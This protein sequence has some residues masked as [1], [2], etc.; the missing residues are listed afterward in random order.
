MNIVEKTHAQ[1]L[2][3]MLNNLSNAQDKSANSFSYDILSA[4]AIVDQELQRIVLELFKKFD[5]DNL[6]D[7][8]LE[9]RVLQITG[10][11]RKEPTKAKG[12]VT[13]TGENGTIIPKN[14]IFLA[15]DTEFLSLNEAKIGEEG[16]VEVLVECLESGATGD[17]IPNSIT[18][19]KKSIAGIVDITNKKEFTNGYEKETDDDLRERYYDKLL[20]PPKGGN[21]AHY[22]LWASEV[23]GVWT[24]KV[25]RTYNGPG[26]V[27][28]VVVGQDR[29]KIDSLKL[30]EIKKHILEEAPIMHE[31]LLVESAK[32][33]ELSINVTVKFVQGFNKEIVKD[34]IKRKVKK[35]LTDIAFSQEFVS[36]AKIGGVILSVEGVEDYSTLK[37]NSTTENTKLAEDEI[38]K[39]I[40]LEVTE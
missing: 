34:E 40:S 11:K 36:Y 25:F 8:E 7:L 5:V 19:T 33:K 28:V 29:N 4:V 38:P 10:L 17:V 14:T 15:G 21:P 23:D 22:K 20:N 13:I 12:M 9:K 3:T 2:E 1:F 30:E 35:Y 37:L 27:R 32:E 24:A 16:N 6:E 31:N 18:K 39:L 26:T